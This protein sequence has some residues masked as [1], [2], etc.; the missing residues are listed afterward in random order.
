MCNQTAD[1]ISLTLDVVPQKME[2]NRIIGPRD[3][4]RT[5][6]KRLTSFVVDMT[7]LMDG[8]A[9]RADGQHYNIMYGE[10]DDGKPA[11]RALNGPQ[12]NNNI[13][14]YI[15]DYNLS[16]GPVWLFGIGKRARTRI[17]LPSEI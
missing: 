13:Y 9:R 11:D 5:P 1:V 2:I 6:I 10:G 7:N 3:W 14:N 4:S 15:R 12:R 17:G 8:P 16:C